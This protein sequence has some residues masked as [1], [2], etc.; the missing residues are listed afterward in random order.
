MCFVTYGGT[1]PKGQCRDVSAFIHSRKGGRHRASA[2]PFAW[3]RS[4]SVSSDIPQD[5]DLWLCGGHLIVRMLTPPFPTSHESENLECPS[6]AGFQPSPRHTQQGKLGT[7]GAFAENRHHVPSVRPCASASKAGVILREMQA[8]RGG[9]A[10]TKGMRNERVSK[11]KTDAAREKQNILRD[12]R[13]NRAGRAGSENNRFMKG[14][15][16]FKGLTPLW[17]KT[18]LNTKSKRNIQ[19]NASVLGK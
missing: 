10:L 9:E 2:L 19:R 5:R 6:P 14:T 18:L 4:A 12:A 16:F 8:W 17:M 7:R 1:P 13:A 3:P 11:M 15:L